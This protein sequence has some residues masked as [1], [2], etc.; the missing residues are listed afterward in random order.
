MKKPTEAP[1]S[2]LTPDASNANRGTARGR[3]M[4]EES[5][6][7]FG[8]LEPGILDKDNRIIGGNKRTEVAGSLGIDNAIIIDIDGNRPVY[9]R[10]N[11]L[12]LTTPKGREAAIAL[13][14]SAQT[15]IE[16]DDA[17]L[18]RALID[19]ID[20]APWFYD[21]E[22]DALGESDGL[23]EGSDDFGFET[24]YVV[25]AEVDTTEERDRLIDLLTEAGM[26]PKV[27]VKT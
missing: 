13:N 17:E 4:I 6:R 19:G 18:S 23:L 27:T 12:D 11:D 21:D 9:V 5:M 20:L 3:G 14:R 7:R 22:L 1:I 25:A 26:K 24:S 2:T 10:R 16:F 8:F 15:S